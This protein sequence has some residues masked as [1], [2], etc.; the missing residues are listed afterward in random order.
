MK[1]DLPGQLDLPI[2]EPTL[3]G[4]VG[5]ITPKELAEAIGVAEQTLAGWR[6]SNKGPSFVKLGKGVFY[7]LADV[8]KWVGDSITSVVVGGAQAVPRDGTVTDE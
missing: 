8:Q 6:C 3:R 2:P 1:I 4:I 5:L 7:R